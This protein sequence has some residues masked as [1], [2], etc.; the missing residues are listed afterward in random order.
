MP[1]HLQERPPSAS[2]ISP[3][4]PASGD[5]TRG[6]NAAQRLRDGA[7]AIRL[8]FTW[9]GTRKTLTAEQKAQAAERFGAEGGYLSAGKKLMDT[10]HPAFRAV[11]SARTR[12]VGYWRWMS[13]PFPEPGIR[14]IRQQD[15]EAVERQMQVFRNELR[16]AVE[17]LDEQY[18]PL[19]TAARERLGRLYNPADYPGSLRGMF[20]LTWDFPSVDPPQYLQALSP[21]LYHREAQRVAARFDEAVQ[22][23]EQAFMDELNKLVAH[24]AER[25]SGKQDGKPKVFRDSAVENLTA[26]FHRFRQLNVRSN[27]QLDELVAQAQQVVRGVKPQEL[28]DN[29]ALRRRVANQLCAVQSALDGLLVDR[30][31]RRILRQTAQPP[32]SPVTGS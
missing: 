12:A 6:A 32:A 29:E 25:L 11:T 18:F 4:P 20:D 14:L 3:A 9:F 10:R 1:P 31:R 24:L 17:E 13:L 23:A 30:P 21:D 8:S 27:A 7:I 22:M 19:R 5:D 28:R 2:Q 26:F 15:L 16:Q